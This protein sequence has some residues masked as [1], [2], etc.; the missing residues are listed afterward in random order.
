MSS[1]KF[2]LQ[3]PIFGKKDYGR[4]LPI[5]TAGTK[6][7]F[8]D[9]KR[10]FAVLYEYDDLSNKDLFISRKDLL[11]AQIGLLNELIERTED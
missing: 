10:E 1:G 5:K 9:N 8:I 6:I 2:R 11:R 3:A 7:R 4:I